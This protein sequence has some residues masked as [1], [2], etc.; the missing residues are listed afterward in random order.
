MI[1]PSVPCNLH[2]IYV[3]TCCASGPGSSMQK[4]NVRR[5]C[6]SET[7]CF[8]STNSLCMIA[9]W[10]AGPPKLIN[11]SLTQNQK[12]SQ[13]FTSLLLSSLPFSPDSI[14]LTATYSNRGYTRGQAT[15]SARSTERSFCKEMRTVSRGTAGQEQLFR[16]HLT[17]D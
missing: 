6:P 9:I 13:N 10:P 15:G 3:A 4:F 7:Q 16:G 2:P 11:P 5:Y 14:I 12:A 1:P 17:V 8:L